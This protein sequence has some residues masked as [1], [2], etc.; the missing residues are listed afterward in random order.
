MK[1]FG[2]NGSPRKGWNTHL[3]VEEVLKGAAERGAETELINLYD[4]NFRGCISCLGCKVKGSTKTG[5]CVT[6]DE[7]SPV[8]EKL[9]NSDGFVIGSPIYISEVTA[10][11]RALFERLTFQ[12]LSYNAGQ[13]AVFTR[14][15]KTGFVFTTNVSEAAYD[16]IGYTSRFTGYKV[17]LERIFGVAE[18]LVSGETHFVNNYDKY[19]LSSFNAAERK[20]RREE[21]FPKHMEAARALGMRLT[22]SV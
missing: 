5:R 20:K 2:I 3:L 17:M 15:I 14:K 18:Y 22:E 12:Y 7:L 10:S 6:N 8:L 9:H 4:L 16:Q 11:V 13:S 19:E 1:I 21:V